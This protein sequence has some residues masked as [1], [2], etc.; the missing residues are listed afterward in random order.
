MFPRAIGWGVFPRAIGWGVFGAAVG[1]NDGIARKMPQKLA[2]G[3]YG[4]FLGGLIGGSTYETLVALVGGLGFNRDVAIAVG[5][6]VGLV[7]LGLCIGCLM[8]LVEDL[9]R[10]AW[11]SFTS[12]KLEGQTRT[13]DPKKAVTAIGR[14]EL[15]DICLLGD[16]KVMDRHAELAYRDGGFVLTPVRGELQV[17]RGGSFVELSGGYALEAGDIIQIGSTRAQFCLGDAQP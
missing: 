1:T 13:L 7:L 17:N 5:G 11:L 12:G 14:A 16:P 10:P 4:G 9:L 6:A 15:A 2:Y 8:G 3:A